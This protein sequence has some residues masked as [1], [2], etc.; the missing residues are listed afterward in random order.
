M[1][2]QKSCSSLATV[3]VAY[4]YLELPPDTAVHARQGRSAE[5][6]A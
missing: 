2:D 6:G 3:R 1:A 5:N 4:L